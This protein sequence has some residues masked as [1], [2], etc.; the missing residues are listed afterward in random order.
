MTI[1]EP[2]GTILITPV[3][4]LVLLFLAIMLIFSNEKLDYVAYSLLFSFIAVCVII[5]YFPDL[6]VND[7]NIAPDVYIFKKFIDF[8]EFEPILFLISMQVIVMICEKHKIFQ[9]IALKVLHVT[10]GNHRTFFYTLCAI[11]A[12]SASIIADITVAIIF[13]PLVVRACKILK[14]DATPYLFAISFTINIGSLYTPFSSSENILIAGVFGLDFLWFLKRFT[15]YVIPVLFLTLYVLDR[16]FLRKIAPPE[17]EQKKILLE[18]MNPNIVIIDKK[19]FILNSIYFVSIIIGFIIFPKAWVISVFGAILMSLLNKIPITDLIA[20]I[21][22]KII[23]F[24]IALFLLIGC[25]EISGIFE[26]VATAAKSIISDNELIAG[27]IILLLIS[28]LSGFLAQVPT[29]LVF[30]TLLQ[31]LY[32][33][34]NGGVVPDLII[35]GFL[36]GI[37]LGSNFLPQGAACDLMALNLAEKNNVTGF[38]Y[39]TLLKNGSLITIFHIFNS[40]IF[41]I[42]YA[43]ITGIL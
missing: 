4:I 18:I 33:V 13:I 35:M 31:N 9:W 23:F 21:D 8:I 39:K 22:W 38:N 30:I 19:Q 16:V 14:I 26:L 12:F 27:I 7:D 20:K 32:N 25:M 10:K 17:E 6:G 24:F 11:S 2:N 15:L 40:I 36:F 3:V 41:M 28:V 42:I 37:N 43:L 5:I 29:A 1:A 34:E